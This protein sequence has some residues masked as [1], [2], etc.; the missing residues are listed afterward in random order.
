MLIRKAYQF[1]LK[2]DVSVEQVARAQLESF[3]EEAPSSVVQRVGVLA[4]CMEKNR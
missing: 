1:K 3:G 4:N 2:T